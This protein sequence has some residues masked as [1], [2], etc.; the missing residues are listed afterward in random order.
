M[1]RLDYYPAKYVLKYAFSLAQE[2]LL[3]GKRDIVLKELLA[4]HVQRMI[5]V[6]K[7][8]NQKKENYYSASFFDSLRLLKN[9]IE[10]DNKAFFQ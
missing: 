5:D 8:R 1:P 6:G 2:N 3:S 10:A 9:A 7:L 4:K